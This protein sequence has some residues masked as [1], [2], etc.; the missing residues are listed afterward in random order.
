LRIAVMMSA[1]VTIDAGVPTKIEPSWALWPAR[2]GTLC[3]CISASDTVSFYENGVTLV[4]LPA[5]SNFVVMS[6]M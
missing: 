6:G 4:N 2:I 3:A 5:A 1:S